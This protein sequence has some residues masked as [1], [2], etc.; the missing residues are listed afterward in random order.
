[1][2]TG[3]ITHIGTVTE[4]TKPHDTRLK[5]EA[6]GLGK[7]IIGAS[8]AHSGICLTVVESGEDW[9]IVEA[10][11]ETLSCTTMKN[12][13]VGEKVNLEKSLKVGDELGGHFVT[14]HV[15]AVGKILSV[16]VDQ[17]SHI[18]TFEIPQKLQ[19]FIAQKGSVTINGISLTVNAVTGNQF[20]VN[21]IP[22][23]FSVTNLGGLVAG[24]NVNIEIDVLARYIAR[25][26]EEDL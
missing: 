7:V 11:E 8:V 5:I 17:G 15:D 2:F 19:K 3:I 4:I 9:L 1:M 16:E 12:W 21:I 24:D 20:A 14:G 18:F 22:H 6:A 13:Q 26:T 10:S 23:T 25:M